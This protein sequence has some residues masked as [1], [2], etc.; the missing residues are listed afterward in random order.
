MTPKLCAKASLVLGRLGSEGRLWVDVSRLSKEDFAF[1]GCRAI[2][3]VK[4]FRV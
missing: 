4:R 2:F 1:G 3:C